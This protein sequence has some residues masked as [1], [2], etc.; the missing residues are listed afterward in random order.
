MKSVFV[1]GESGRMGS[2]VCDLLSH[3]NDLNYSGGFRRGVDLHEIAQEIDIIIDFSLPDTLKDL[4]EFAKRKKACVVSGTTGLN[5]SQIAQLQTLGETVPVFWSANMSFGV[6]LLCQLA[7]SLAK[8]DQFYDFSLSETHH[9][10]KKD[11]P[12][13]TALLIEKEVKKATQKQIPI[14]AFREGEVFGI[15][16]FTALSPF[17]KI[18]INHE[19]LD[20]KLFAKGALDIAGWLWQ[21]PPGFYE[22]A[23]FFS[24]DAASN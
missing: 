8:W 1:F 24:D 16:Q 19:A 12:S 17:E 3:H 5:D 18:E 9:I 14:Q 10:H 2:H 4:V 22:M 21:K 15:H 6:F 11:S 20:R 7:K 13:G 23:D